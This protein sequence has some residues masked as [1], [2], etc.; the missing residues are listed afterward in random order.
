MFRQSDQMEFMN[1]FW[2]FYSVVYN[3]LNIQAD[4]VYPQIAWKTK[5]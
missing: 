2:A 3:Q 1:I 4:L 5:Q